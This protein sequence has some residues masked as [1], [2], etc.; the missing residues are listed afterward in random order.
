VVDI[1]TYSYYILAFRAF[2]FEVF[3]TQFHAT[4][5]MIPRDN[6]FQEEREENG[7][8]G[9]ES[10]SKF[11]PLEEYIYIYLTYLLGF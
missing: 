9:G 2:E 7:E 1:H 10:P 3:A 11:F 6:F 4:D 5:F 8:G